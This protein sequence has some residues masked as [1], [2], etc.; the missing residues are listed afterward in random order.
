VKHASKQRP[1]WYRLASI[2]LRAQAMY[3]NAAT[4]QP[5]FPAESVALRFRR[6][7]RIRAAMRDL[8]LSE[9]RTA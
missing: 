7:I 2:A 1:K 6:L 4:F 5:Y 8:M 9:G 3:D